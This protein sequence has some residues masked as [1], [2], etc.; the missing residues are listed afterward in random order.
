MLESGHEGKFFDYVEE[1]LNGFMM[2]ENM[3]ENWQGADETTNSL[4]INFDN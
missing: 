4:F 2:L 3:P 1:G